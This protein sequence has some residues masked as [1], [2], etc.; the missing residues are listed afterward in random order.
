VVLLLLLLLRKERVV[1]VQLERAV[2]T[3]FASSP[4]CEILHAFTKLD[5]HDIKS[6]V[7][8]NG[9]FIRCCCVFANVWTHTET[10]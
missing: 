3:R 4:P 9:L 6:A 10:T 5:K 2:T 7:K 1:V 8:E